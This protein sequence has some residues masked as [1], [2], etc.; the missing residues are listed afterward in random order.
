MSAY[1]IVSFTPKDPENLQQYAAAVP[2]TL[3]SHSG[4]V[5]VKGPADSL[6]G[7][8]D[9]AMQVIIAFPSKEEA[10]RWY[11]SKEYQALIPVRDAG[12]DSQFQ[13]IGN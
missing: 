9:Y 1:I 5:V 2:S 4:E 6:H 3:A 13:L 12:M 7:T 11:H 8:V 10:T